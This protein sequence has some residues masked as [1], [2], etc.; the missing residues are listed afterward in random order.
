MKA[1]MDSCVYLGPVDPPKEPGITKL[2][3][4]L[5]YDIA[6]RILGAFIPPFRSY[7]KVYVDLL[8]PLLAV[9]LL[10]GFVT[11]GNSL[12]LVRIEFTPV[13]FI[14]W[15]SFLMPLFCYV[16]GRLGQAQIGFLKTISLIGYSYYGHLFT[17]IASFLCFQE[18]SNFFFFICLITF[19]GLSNFRLAIIYLRSIPAPA[20]RVI[21]CA[22][23]ASVNI[24]S[25]IFL[26]FA[27]MHRHYVYIQQ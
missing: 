21:I 7:Q 6:I 25:V 19:G 27:Y 8:G 13:E 5:P 3:V 12:K 18:K 11:Y 2:F 4:V 15:Y 16:I 9:L 20:V 24:L 23:I 17:L 1:Q 14:F 22:T 10:A 26:H